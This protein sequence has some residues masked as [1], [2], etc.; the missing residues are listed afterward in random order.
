MIHIIAY[1]QKFKVHP[2]FSL[3]VGKEKVSEK[4]PIHNATAV[5]DIAAP[6]MRF[7]KISDRITQTI[8]ASVSE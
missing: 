6:R 1:S 7:G 8:G 3:I 4:L 5:I 2:R